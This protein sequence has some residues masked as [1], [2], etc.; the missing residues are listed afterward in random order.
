MAYADRFNS[1]AK[2][3]HVQCKLVALINKTAHVEIF[4][5]SFRLNKT[6]WSNSSD[7]LSD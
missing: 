2:L 5:N 6:L 4:A 7:L 1:K 3:K